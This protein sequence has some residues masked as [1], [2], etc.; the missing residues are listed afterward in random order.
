MAILSFDVGQKNLAF[1]VIN[2]LGESIKI[3]KWDIIDISF[4]SS[5]DE[6]MNNFIQKYKK[7][8]I[9][10]LK[11][12]MS[13]YGMET[14]NLKKKE[15]L[16]KTKKYFID[17]GLIKKDVS[18]M[19]TSLILVKKLDKLNILQDIDTVLIENQPCMTNPTMKSV[20]MILYTYFIIRGFIDSCQNTQTNYQLKTL[21]F[22]S[23]SNKLKKCNNI[24]QFKNRTKNYKDRKKLAI[25]YCEY[26]LNNN[27]EQEKILYFNT[28]L[29]KD[30][31]ADCYL[32]AIYYIDDFQEKNK[33][34]KK[35]GK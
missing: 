9:N 34:K 32:Q 25:E 13:K 23:A 18:I 19:D 11:E 31:L 3:F 29:K 17:N 21:K 20:Q 28:H 6:T 7:M 30:D 1:C 33:P 15:L 16:D 27:D 10:E 22:I 35:K 26:V 2:Q 4:D 5:S 24:E 12:N 14:N 8:K